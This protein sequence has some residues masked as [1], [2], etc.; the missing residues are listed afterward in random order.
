MGKSS[1][2]Q[3]MA[4]LWGCSW[5]DTDDV[6][7]ETVGR[8]VA[9]L[10]REDGEPAFRDLELAALI[11]ALD[12]DAIVATGGGV[13]C[14]ARARD[15][16]KSAPTIWLDCDD[17]VILARLSDGDRPL[18][19]QDPRGSLARLRDVRVGWYSEVSRARVEASGT[20]DDVTGRI[21]A[22]LAGANG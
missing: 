20:L 12:T 1:V 11:A 21:V 3:A 18:L 14:A 13:V 6:I 15:L 2:A 7:A 8:P 17:Q 22:A 10:L 5:V 9:E 19:G 16:L 4:E